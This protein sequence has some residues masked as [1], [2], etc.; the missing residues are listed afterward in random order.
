[1]ALY[2]SNNVVQQSWRYFTFLQIEA[3]DG[4]DKEIAGNY[5]VYVL[6]RDSTGAVVA[7]SHIQILVGD[8]ASN[9][10]VYTCNSDSELFDTPMDKVVS[11]KKRNRTLPLKMICTDGSGNVMGA[12]DISAPIVQVL[13]S[14]PTEA[15]TEDDEEFLISGKGTDGNQFVFDP[16]TGV[17]Q[18]NLKTKNFSGTGTYSISVAPGGTDVLLVSPTG[19]F[20]I[21]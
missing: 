21:Q 9:D 16:N 14:A 3:L 1:M 19:T 17:W 2:A 4:Y 6:V 10:R 8:V 18:F 7:L 20:V 11:V 12:G 15:V 5:L 13:K